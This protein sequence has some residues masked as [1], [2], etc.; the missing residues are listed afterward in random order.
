MRYPRT[1]GTIFNPNETIEDWYQ[2]YDC[3]LTL[4]IIKRCGEIASNLGLTDEGVVCPICDKKL[5]DF[6]SLTAHRRQ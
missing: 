4:E 2:P 1:V 3:S 6:K 5:K